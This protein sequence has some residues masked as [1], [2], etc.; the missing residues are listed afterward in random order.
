VMN[1]VE[2]N[3][4]RM[5]V[6]GMLQLKISKLKANTNLGDIEIDSVDICSF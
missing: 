3:V 6:V 2:S 5:L 4:K 1:Q